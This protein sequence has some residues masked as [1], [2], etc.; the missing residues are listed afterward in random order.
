MVFVEHMGIALADQ[1][2]MFSHQPL[3]LKDEHLIHLLMHGHLLAQQPLWH[4]V[5]IGIQMHIALGIHHPIVDLS[6]IHI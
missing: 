3:S 2:C 6:L 4:R 5:A 1:P